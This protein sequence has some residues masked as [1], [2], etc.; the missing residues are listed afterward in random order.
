MKFSL[1]HP[2]RQRHSLAYN[3]ALDIIM[4]A[5][6]KNLEYVM[7]IDSD[8]NQAQ[9]YTENVK[10]INDKYHCASLLVAGSRNCV[11]ALNIGA[12]YSTGD[13]LIYVS[14]D[15]IFPPN[16][17][18]LI[19]KAA[20]GK[21]DFIMWVRDGIQDDIMTS[22]VMSRKHFEYLGYAYHGSYVSMYADNDLTE[23]AKRVGKIIM[24]KHILIKH[25]HPSIGGNPRD[26]TFHRQ[27]DPK[28]YDD[29]KKTFERLMKEY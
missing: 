4:K 11:Q 16:W 22:I 10:K 14:E 29:G 6:D 13:I 3:T 2:S 20:N 28:H 7:V 19:L 25:N 8:D 26:E 9:Q 21:D 23:V 24:A 15:F 12:H 27:N 17:D 1:I 5:K 18:E